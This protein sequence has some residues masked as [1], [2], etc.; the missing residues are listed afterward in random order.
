MGLLLHCKD[1]IT[2]QGQAAGIM[3]TWRAKEY[4]HPSHNV[5]TKIWIVFHSW[6]MPVKERTW[7]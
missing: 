7:P 5:L 6:A 3:P 2:L 4:E 1:G